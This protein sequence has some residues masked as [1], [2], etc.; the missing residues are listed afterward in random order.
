M[1]N[2]SSSFAFGSWRSTIGES[3]IDATS[4]P[5]TQTAGQ[6]TTPVTQMQST[7]LPAHIF[8]AIEA[9]RM[10]R[11]P[12]QAPDANGRATVPMGRGFA[13]WQRMNAGAHLVWID[14]QDGKPR[15]I[16]PKQAQVLALALELIGKGRGVTMRDMAQTLRMAPS[17]ISRALTKLQSFG[18]I[19]VIVGRGRYAG[20][21]IFRTVKGDGMERFAQAAKARVRRWSEAVRRRISR[22]EVNV[23]PYILDR[24]RGVDSLYYYLYSLDTSKSATLTA[25]LKKDWTPQELREAGII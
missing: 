24:E 10:E 18:V 9:D 15:A 1:R 20:L 5:S 23:A 7:R 17:T 6:R 21:V 3:R 8:Y 4:M 16:T 19:G 13:L 14:D 11:N 2:T 25:Q 12:V 22:L